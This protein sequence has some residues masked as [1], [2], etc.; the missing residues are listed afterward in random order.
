LSAKLLPETIYEKQGLVD[1]NQLL[2]ISG[3][4]RKAQLQLAEEFGLQ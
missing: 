4:A 1:R 3:R 2:D